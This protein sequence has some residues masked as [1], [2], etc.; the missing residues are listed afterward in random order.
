MTRSRLALV[1]IN[2]IMFVVL[3]AVA[4]VACQSLFAQPRERNN[5]K[6][7]APPGAALSQIVFPDLRDS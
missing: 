3:A 2:I 1:A 6:E 5:K 4:A 7:T